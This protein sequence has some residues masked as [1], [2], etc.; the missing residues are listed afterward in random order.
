MPN[1]TA[2]GQDAAS[3]G[4]DNLLNG[5]SSRLGMSFEEFEAVMAIGSSE[6]ESQ[7]TLPLNIAAG[8]VC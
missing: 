3:T 2:T 8:F 4:H 5:W 6:E 7:Q 1:F